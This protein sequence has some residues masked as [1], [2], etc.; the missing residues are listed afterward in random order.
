MKAMLQVLL[1]GLVL[2]SIMMVWLNRQPDRWIVP[3]RFFLFSCGQR[4]DQA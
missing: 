3:V 4:S 1:L 2:F